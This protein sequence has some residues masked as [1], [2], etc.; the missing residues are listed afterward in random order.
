MTVTALNPQYSVGRSWFRIALINFLVAGLTGAMLRL[1]FVVEVPL[2]EFT[3]GLHAHSHTAML[4]WIYMG[5]YALAIDMFLPKD[6]SASPFYARLFWI[7]E[8]SVIGIYISMLFLGYHGLSIAFLTAHVILSYIFAFRLMRDMIAAKCSGMASRFMKTSLWFMILSTLALWAIGPIIAFDLMGSAFYYA[9]IQFFLH[10]QFNGWFIFA[11]LAILFRILQQMDIRI[12]HKLMRPFFIMMI[13]SC[14]L[15]YVLAVTWSTP[16]RALFWINSLGV[17]I[18]LLALLIF[19]RIMIPLFKTARSR[20]SQGELSLF[21]VAM[22][23][24]AAK[25]IVQAAVVVPYIATVAYTIR[26]YV[27][28][29]IHLILLGVVTHMILGAASRRGLINLSAP[30]TRT[31]VALIFIGFVLSELLLFVQGTM[32][33]GT[34][35]IPPSLLRNFIPCIAT[36]PNRRV[37]DPSFN[38]S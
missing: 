20:L 2:F 25:I 8:A 3:K 10:F 28:G 18:Q 38:I 19:G 30:G 12:D 29:F 17:A 34:L 31:G 23:A 37:Y 1:M 32:F 15:T 11:A 9:T 6:V 5:I 36:D 16:I 21:G 27:I 13:L 26:N 22:L 14:T 4:G 24:F 33:W 35:G 7:T